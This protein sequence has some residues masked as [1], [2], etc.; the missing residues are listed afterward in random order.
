MEINVSRF[1]TKNHYFAICCL[2]IIHSNKNHGLLG[3]P[4]IPIQD[5]NT[6][7][8][9]EPNSRKAKIWYRRK[10]DVGA[11]KNAGQAF[12][13]KRLSSH[14]LFYQI[15]AFRFFSPSNK[16]VFNPP[17]SPTVDLDSQKKEKIPYPRC[18]FGAC[19]RCERAF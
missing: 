16:L 18:G 6:N 8:H 5:L 7:F 12:S 9:L 19:L 3:N 13:T 14:F 10:C 17:F 15:S 2:E 11:S 4:L 1:P